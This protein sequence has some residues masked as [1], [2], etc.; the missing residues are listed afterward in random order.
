MYIMMDCKV[1]VEDKVKCMKVLQEVEIKREVVYIDIY[2]FEF[3]WVLENERI[4]DYY[5][6][7]CVLY[8]FKFML[9]VLWEKILMYQLKLIFNVFFVYYN[10]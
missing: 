5:G 1:S 3:N 8:W 2:L 6:D 7:L 10:Y 4:L 9:V